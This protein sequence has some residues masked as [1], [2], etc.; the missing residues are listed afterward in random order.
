[1]RYLS[2]LIREWPLLIALGLPFLT[3]ACGMTFRTSIVE[4]DMAIAQRVCQAWQP[5]TYSSRDTPQTRTEA[6]ANNAAREA[7]GCP[8]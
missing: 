7:F 6:R 2:R 5:V 8:K 3:A 4:T 1:M